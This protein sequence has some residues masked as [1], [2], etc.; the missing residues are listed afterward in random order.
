MPGQEFRLRE[1]EYEALLAENQA[2]GKVLANDLYVVE[3]YG[4]D[5]F[6]TVPK[7]LPTGVQRPAFSL[8]PSDYIERQDVIPAVE[9]WMHGQRISY[10]LAYNDQDRLISLRRREGNSEHGGPLTPIGMHYHVSSLEHRQANLGLGSTHI[11][12]GYVESYD[13]AINA[14]NRDALTYLGEIAPTVH[15]NAFLEQ[16]PPADL[17]IAMLRSYTMGLRQ[18]AHTLQRQDV[19]DQ[20]EALLDRLPH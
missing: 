19:V 1:E 10:A 11:P 16:R 3:T 13:E 5:V 2:H 6:T 18:G 12:L 14:L 4:P 17:G 20:T 15:M 7:N 9:G 8:R